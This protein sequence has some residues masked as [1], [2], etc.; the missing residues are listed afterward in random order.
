MKVGSLGDDVEGGDRF[1]VLVLGDSQPC[2]R[3]RRSRGQS[4][5]ISLGGPG[6]DVLRVVGQ[7]QGVVA[8]I[9]EEG[10]RVAGDVWRDVMQ[11]PA[12]ME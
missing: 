2:S 9:R 12:E 7:C 10:A 6:E 1:Q 8:V 5:E 4:L 11:F 3:D